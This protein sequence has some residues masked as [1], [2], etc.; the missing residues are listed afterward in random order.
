MVETLEQRRVQQALA[1]MLGQRRV[2]RA[3]VETLEQRRVR[4][5][6]AE[7]LGQRRVR[8]AMAEMLEQRRVR[9]AMAAAQTTVSTIGLMR[10]PLD[11]AHLVVH[12]LSFNGQLQRA[13]ARCVCN[14]AYLT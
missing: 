14:A 8:R 4:R 9:R 13:G 5:A 2:R 1:E 3:M 12:G 11:D 6:M 7:M 10:K